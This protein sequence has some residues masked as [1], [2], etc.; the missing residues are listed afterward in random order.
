MQL[1]DTILP[2]DSAPVTS[3]VRAAEFLGNLTPS[4]YSLEGRRAGLGRLGPL[5]F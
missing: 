1:H 2:N 4:D 3:G 5:L